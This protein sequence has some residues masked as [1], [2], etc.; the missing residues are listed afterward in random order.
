MTAR[1]D[2]ERARPGA[3]VRRKAASSRALAAALGLGSLLLASAAHADDLQQ[4]ELGKTRFDTGQYDEA[5]TR[6]ADMLNPAHAPCDAMPSGVTGGC[7]LTDPALIERA[8]TLHAASLVA[9]KRE[10][11]ADAQIETIL[12]QN[13]GFTPDPAVFPDEVIDRF[14]VV[15][16][17]LRGELEAAAAKKAEEERQRRLKSQRSKQDEQRWIQA[18]IK[19][20]SE[21]RVVVKN[22]RWIGAIPFGVGQFQNG[23]KRLGWVFAVGEAALGA[24]SI[25]TAEVFAYYSRVDPRAISSESRE[26]LAQNQ[27]TA[28]F[29]NRLAFGLWAA[30]TVTGVVQAQIAFVPETV[31]VR[32]RPVPE[33]PKRSALQ[34]APTFAVGSGIG[35]G[36]VGRF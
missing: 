3:R 32:Q 31:T 5:A 35:L 2:E 16:A 4:F 7:R 20:A 21:E 17:R 23:D 12:R 1:S 24:T 18:L 26:A 27:Q 34:I 22:S 11:E 29:I 15:R 30:M 25:A 28:A 8:R 10:T 9:L 33:R 19:A 13:P 14:T 6:F 36:V